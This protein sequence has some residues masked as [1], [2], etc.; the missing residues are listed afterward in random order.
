MNLDE[1][2]NLWNSNTNGPTTN[3]KAEIISRFTAVLR[4][5]HRQE[6][7]WL[8]WTFFVLTILTGFVG[9]VVFGTDKVKVS[10]EWAVIPL[11]LIPWVFACLFLKRFLS[12]K[13]TTARGDVTIADSLSAAMAANAAER[14]KLKAMGWMYLVVLPVLGL[15]I[16]QLHAVGKVSGRELVSMVTFLGSALALSGG[17]VL[18][19]Y[20]LSLVPKG[21]KLKG[22]LSQIGQ[23]T[24]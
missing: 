7:A 4:R 13:G 5:R 17:A 10:A 15:A 2:Q 8:V 14:G 3:E 6:L 9:W 21:Q 11:L 22:L 24:G 1:L 12:E 20:W 19:R 18:A 16:W 23:V